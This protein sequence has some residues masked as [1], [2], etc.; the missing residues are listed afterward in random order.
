MV[1]MITLMKTSLF[2][3]AIIRKLK[4]ITLLRTGKEKKININ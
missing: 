2:Y 1:R 4:T 3:P